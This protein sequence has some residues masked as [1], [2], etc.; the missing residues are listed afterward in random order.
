MGSATTNSVK[1][2]AV[3]VM[4][5]ATIRMMTMAWRRYWLMWRSLMSPMRAITQQT[6]GSS[7]T[8]PITRL[9]ISSVSIYDCRVSMLATSALTW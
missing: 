5:A 6:T 2:S 1:A 7:N 8:T 3:G 4:T 9:I